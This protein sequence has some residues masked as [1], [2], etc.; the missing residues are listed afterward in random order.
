MRL[1]VAIYIG[2]AFLAVLPYLGI[3]DHEFVFDDKVVILKNPVIRDFDWSGIFAK[4]YWVSEAAAGLYRPLTTLGFAVDWALGNG[5]PKPFLVGNI[6]LHLLA[7]I[8]VLLLMK[9]L[10]PGRERAGWFIAALFAVHPLHVEAVA[11]IVGLAEVLSAVLVLLCYLSWLRAEE[12]RSI[13]WRLLPPLLWLGAILAKETAILFP[14]LLLFHRRGWLPGAPKGSFRKSDLAW[15]VA[16]LVVAMLRIH[17]LGGIRAPITD[18]VDN[19]L[20]RVGPLERALGAGGVLAR[21]FLQALTGRRL[22]ADY[23]YA[24]IQPGASLYAAGAVTLALV[25]AVALLAFRR[26]PRSIEAWGIAFFLVIW[27]VTSNLIVPIGTAQADRLFYLPLLGFLAAGVAVLFRIPF[28]AGRR[29]LTVFLALIVLAGAVRS[30]ERARDWQNERTLYESAVRVEPKSVKARWNL[31]VVLLDDKNERSAARVLEILEPVAKWT[32]DHASTL[33]RQAAAFL[34]LSQNAQADSL[35][36]AALRAGTPDS[37][38]AHIELGNIALERQDGEAAL[39]EFDIAGRMNELPDHVAI[40][41]ASA[42][43]I[44]GRYR[45]SADAWGPVLARYPDS[46]SVRVA[47]AYNLRRCGDA[48]GRDRNPGRRSEAKCGSQIGERTRR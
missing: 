39:R 43:S 5:S 29:I 9:R 13:L 21:Q 37:V 15:A 4:P 34:F 44:L 27:I 47:C 8:L 12:T 31:S 19:P 28:P 40:G 32:P 45:E 17:A 3:L 1:R 48:A 14:L 6:T 7:T 20:L 46:I 41:R 18:P 38:D 2:L 24:A 33:F 25:A 36:R 30:L 42:L 23:S 22:S 16:F 26:A 35:L 11:G 10:F